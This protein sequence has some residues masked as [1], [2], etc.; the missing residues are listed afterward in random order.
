M[1]ETHIQLGSSLYIFLSFNQPLSEITQII[2]LQANTIFTQG[3]SQI[4]SIT[5]SNNGLNIVV[6]LDE[7]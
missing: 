7:V 1:T 4:T 6:N 2:P 3:Q 5:W